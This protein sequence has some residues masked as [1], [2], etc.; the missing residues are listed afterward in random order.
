MESA[1]P[2]ETQYQ[3]KVRTQC[4]NIHAFL[5][6]YPY[7]KKKAYHFKSITCYRESTV[8]TISE[9][10]LINTELEMLTKTEVLKGPSIRLRKYYYFICPTGV[11]Q[12]VHNIFKSYTLSSKAHVYCEKLQ[13]SPKCS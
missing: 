11:N 6:K 4:R 7:K 8:T 1:R 2:S 12:Q 5:L 9:I 10:N 3:P 13:A